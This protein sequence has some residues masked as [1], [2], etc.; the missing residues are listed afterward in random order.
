MALSFF[1]FRALFH[2]TQPA[3]VFR[4]FFGIFIGG[5][6]IIHSLRETKDPLSAA[7][8]T[9]YLPPERLPAVVWLSP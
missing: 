2:E 9:S 3:D 5:R 4:I 6:G 1:P 7:P 8:L